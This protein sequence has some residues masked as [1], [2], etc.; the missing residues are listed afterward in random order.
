MKQVNLRY[1]EQSNSGLVGKE[2]KFNS[3][4]SLDRDMTKDNLF[5]QNITSELMPIMDNYETIGGKISDFSSQFKKMD[6]AKEKN[7]K[8]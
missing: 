4:F 1:F 2:I 7:L 6:K 3:T 8:M 5:A